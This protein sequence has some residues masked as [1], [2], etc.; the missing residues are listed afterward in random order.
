MMLQRS[1]DISCTAFAS[2]ASCRE[3]PTGPKPLLYITLS[4][5]VKNF[6]N[7][8][9]EALEA[10]AERDMAGL[11][12][13]ISTMSFGSGEREQL[14]HQFSGNVGGALGSAPALAKTGA[15]LPPIFEA[16]RPRSRQLGASLGSDLC[17]YP[18][19]GRRVPVWDDMLCEHA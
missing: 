1:P 4:Q 12:R 19:L 7:S 3:A 5:D 8:V 11:G 9:Q 10:E 18:D 15:L 2:N 13:S 14:A 16:C 17:M 6:G